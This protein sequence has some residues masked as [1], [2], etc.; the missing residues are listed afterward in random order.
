MYS[1]MLEL[2]IKIEEEF[3]SGLTYEEAYNK[4]IDDYKK[5]WEPYEG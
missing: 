1:R 4:V 2:A 5:E 3:Q